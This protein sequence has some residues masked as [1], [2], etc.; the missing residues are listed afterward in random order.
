MRE[1]LVLVVPSFPKLS[2][3]F[4]VSKF[5]GVLDCGWDAH[6]VCQSSHGQEWARFPELCQNYGLRRRVHLASPTTSAW[7]AMM[8]VPLSVLR[9]FKNPRAVGRYLGLGRRAGGWAALKN[10]YLDSAIAA[11]RPA[12][13]HFEY[14]PLAVG[15]THLKRCLGA[16]LTCSF[17]GHDLNFVARDVPGFYNAVWRDAD[18]VHLLGTDLWRTAQQ[19]GCPADKKRV[20]IPP[21][22]DTS[23]FCPGYSAED[24]GVGHGDQAFRILSVGRLHWAK[25][26]E[27]NLEAIARLRN[28]GVSCSYRIAGGGD[29][30]EALAFITAQ[31]GLERCVEFLG[32]LGPAQV[33]EQ[34]ARADVLLHGAVSEGFCNAVIEAQSMEVPVVCSDAGGLPENIKDGE[35]G[36]VVPRR[37]PESTAWKLKTLADDP[38]LRRRMGQ[39]GREHV[40]QHFQLDRQIE[41][42]DNFYRDI[43]DN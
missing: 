16:K 3:T 19:R 11:L 35:S 2:E 21:A 23:Y 37:H 18:G 10:A 29:Q 13:V 22:I 34:L 17:R 7:R 9:F 25:G 26:Y 27:Y 38:L 4:I 6:I 5:R 40:L 8:S 36:Y 14:G 41:A 43:L 15:R 32:A 28:L 42:F 12:I 24:A 1:K 30:L 33:R 20:L 31:L 39:A